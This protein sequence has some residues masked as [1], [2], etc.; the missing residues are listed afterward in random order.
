MADFFD[1]VVLGDGRGDLAALVTAALL[2]RRGRRVLCAGFSVEERYTLGPWVLPTSPVGFVGLE[3]PAWRRVLDE[4]SLGATLRRRLELHRPSWQLCLPDARLDVGDELLRELSRE[5]ASEQPM[6]E[7]AMTRLGQISGELDSILAQDPTI[8][9]VGFWDRRESRR[10]SARLPDDHGDV[11][12][13]LVAA[14][15]WRALFSLP[16][17]FGTDLVRPGL[18]ASARAFELHRTVHRLDGGRRALAAILMER[19]QHHAGELNPRRPTQILTK[20][21]RVT[22]VLFDGARE[23]VGCDELVVALSPDR[24]LPLLDGE[25]PPKALVAES[26]RLHA[27]RHRYLLH[28]AVPVDALPD[29]LGRLA[30]SVGDSGAP[31]EGANALRLHTTDG[32]GQHAVLTVEALA[33]DGSLAGLSSLRKGIRAHLDRLFPFLSRNLLLVHSPHDG[34]PPEGANIPGAPLP[35]QPMDEVWDDGDGERAFGITGIGYETGLKNLT[36]ASR[37]ILPGL[38]LEGELTAGWI[39]ARLVGGT[40]KKRV[41]KQ[42]VLESG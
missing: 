16:A 13:E 10:E 14:S 2:A 21:G 1:V 29:P 38:G 34:I 30:Y 4:L 28:L 19:V 5:A 8:P 17:M 12:A 27:K 32:Y 33:E 3:S 20:R 9:A 7:A 37:Q 15:P 39:A 24:L 11:A 35:I 41:Q 36:L 31:L 26:D 42:S 25:K 6:I 40:D 18:V 23:P 22:G